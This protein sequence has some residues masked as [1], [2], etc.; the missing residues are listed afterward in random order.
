MQDVAYLEKTIRIG[1]VK[2]RGDEHICWLTNSCL[3]EC[4]LFHY[5]VIQI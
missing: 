2:H 5:I 3:L 4:K 1:V